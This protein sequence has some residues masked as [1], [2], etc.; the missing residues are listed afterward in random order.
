MATLG[1]SLYDHLYLGCQE[2]KACRKRRDGQLNK[3]S[4]SS[5][6]PASSPALHKHAHLFITDIVVII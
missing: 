4:S 5:S 2:T 1:N 3:M 6:C